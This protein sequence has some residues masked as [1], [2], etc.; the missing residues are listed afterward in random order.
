MIPWCKK[1]RMLCFVLSV[2]ISLTI[3]LCF[4]IC[5][6]LLLQKTT[7]LD[8]SE[9]SLKVWMNKQVTIWFLNC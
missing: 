8:V 9:E 4:D 2:Y 7:A 6:C 3:F 5:V 1:L